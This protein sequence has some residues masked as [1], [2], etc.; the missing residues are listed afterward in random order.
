MNVT[1]A[2]QVQVRAVAWDDPEAVALRDAMTA[3]VAPRYADRAARLPM[4][5]G[6]AVQPAELVYAAVAYRGDRG[7]GHIALRRLPDTAARPG[8]GPD[9]EGPGGPSE[10]EI[11]RMFVLP[12]VR[13]HGIGRLLLSAAENVAAATG[14]RRVVLQTGDRQPEA[15]ALYES[16]GYTRIPIFAPYLA[17]PYS[18]CFEKPLGSG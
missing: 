12:S 8:P 15:A 2:Q 7:V 10:L 13:G 11:K 16:A 18:L 14:A 5:A 6:M 17:L 4:P 9:G 3:E 1:V